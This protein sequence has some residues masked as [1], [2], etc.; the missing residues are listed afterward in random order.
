MTALVAGLYG[1]VIGSFLNV[2]IHRVP[3][4]RSVVRPPSACPHCGTRISARDNVPVVSW[5]VLRGRC[6]SCAAPISVRYPLVELL[7]GALFA[8]VALRF[9]WS[10]T[11]PAMLIFV[12]GLVALAFCD[13]DRLVLPKR[14]VYATA[15]LVAVALLSAAAATGQW[16]RLAVSV[17][18]AA[19]GLVVFR[20][21]YFISPRAMGFGDVR[22]AP[23]ISGTLGWLGVGYALVGFLLANVL[24][25]VIGLALIA[26]RRASRR[27]RLPYG[28]F[29]AAG[30]MLAL[31]L[32]GM[33]H[34]VA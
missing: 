30:A 11:L 34:G 12:A 20:L 28:V 32:G 16:H 22:L 3:E 8:L 6:R 17:A 23:L 13:L 31:P 15:V 1:L 2:V 7:T 21:I 33:L 10:P 26:G 14:I 18:C 25:V 27:T 4:R 29:L 5:L 19:A 24:G 9:G